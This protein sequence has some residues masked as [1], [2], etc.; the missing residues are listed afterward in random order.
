MVILNMSLLCSGFLLQTYPRNWA[1]VGPTSMIFPASP[2]PS[3]I[4]GIEANL[5][6]FTRRHVTRVGAEHFLGGTIMRSP[7]WR[8]PRMAPPRASTMKLTR[9][10]M[11]KRKEEIKKSGNTTDESCCLLKPVIRDAC[12]FL[13]VQ[14]GNI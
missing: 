7:L 8:H 10:L 9:K 6:L 1:P 4:G 14:T 3:T 5:C 13:L 11:S 2:S 12:F